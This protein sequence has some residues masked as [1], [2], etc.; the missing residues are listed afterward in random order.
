MLRREL[1]A[2]FF[3]MGLA[4][5]CLHCGSESDGAE[6][7]PVQPKFSALN[8]HIFSKKCSFRACH[9][10]DAN[11]ALRLDGAGA[12]ENLVE[13]PSEQLT[14]MDRVSPG[15]PDASYLFLKLSEE[16]PPMGVRM[17]PNQPLETNE[18]EAIRLWIAAGANND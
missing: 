10:G 9:G 14:G 1:A 12:Y 7:P 17:P 8:E 3:A 13:V 2:R 15:N 5:A 18:I 11:A 4:F 16:R 6:S